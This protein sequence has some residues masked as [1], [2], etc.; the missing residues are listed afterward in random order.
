M[1]NVKAIRTLRAATVAFMRHHWTGTL[2]AINALQGL[3]NAVNAV[4]APLDE[5]PTQAD[6]LELAREA[7]TGAIRCIELEHGE[8]SAAKQRIALAA[9]EAA[10]PAAMVWTDAQIDELARKHRMDTTFYENDPMS[11]WRGFARQMLAAALPVEE[12]PAE[13]EALRAQLAK[14][15]A[16]FEREQSRA[17]AAETDAERYRWLRAQHWNN[18]DL[19]VVANPKVAVRLGHDCPS[20]ERLDAAIDAAMAAEPQE[21]PK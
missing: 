13:L 1:S 9:I 17:D 11:C 4:C 18:A 19:C 21:Q 5:Q 14:A 20:L 6:A 16:A 2:P 3:L 7:L 15:A 10:P 8:G 12:A